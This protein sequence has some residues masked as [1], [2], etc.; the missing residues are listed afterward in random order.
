M[1]TDPS[2]V[3]RR[4]ALDGVARRREQA[5]WDRVASALNRTFGSAGPARDPLDPDGWIATGRAQLAAIEQR[6]QERWRRNAR[7]RE[8]GERAWAEAN[9]RKAAESASFPMQPAASMW[10]FQPRAWIA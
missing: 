8:A 2:E 6:G 9:R 4:A 10:R 5:R 3:I 7:G 1:A